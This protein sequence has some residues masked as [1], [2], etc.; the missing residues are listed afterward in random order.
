MRCIRFVGVVTHTLAS[1]SWAPCISCS[2]RDTR[3]SCSLPSRETSSEASP[4]LPTIIAAVPEWDACGWL[5]GRHDGCDW[6]SP[7]YDTARANCIDEGPQING[8]ERL[9]KERE[10]NRQTM[11]KPGAWAW[12]N[13]SCATLPNSDRLF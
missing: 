6:A 11:S 13:S 4:Q 7:P 10:A 12:K 5:T 3:P 2:R 1:R 9:G 8:T